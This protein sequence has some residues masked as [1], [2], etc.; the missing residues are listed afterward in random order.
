MKLIACSQQI[1]IA[2]RSV[3]LFSLFIMMHTKVLAQ[4][5]SVKG[6]VTDTKGTPLNGATVKIKGTDK[7]TTTN[8]QG[9]FSLIGMLWAYFLTVS[10][11]F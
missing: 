1:A 9:F 11:K 4:T 8:E 2:V 7:A 5:N 6:K 3:F 10:Y